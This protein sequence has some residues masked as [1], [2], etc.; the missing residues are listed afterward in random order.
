MAETY[1]NPELEQG[2]VM[3]ENEI[4]LEKIEKE[5]ERL[6]NE[7]EEIEKALIY[8]YERFYKVFK[9]IQKRG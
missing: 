8:E 7:K 3:D 2:K 6:K 9:K 5:I 1:F 4:L